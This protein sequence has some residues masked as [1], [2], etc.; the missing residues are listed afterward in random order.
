MIDD[1]A[2]VRDLMRRYL[3]REGFDV[4]TAGGGQ[5]GL[6]FA[7]ELKPSVITLDVFMPD[8]DGWS[9]LQAIKAGRGAKRHTGHHDD[10]L[11]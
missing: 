7:R 4:V 3:S 2:T 11:R 6:K 10:D 5:E 8:M 9:V 1:D